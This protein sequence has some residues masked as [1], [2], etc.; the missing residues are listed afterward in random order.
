MEQT[1]DKPVIDMLQED[2]KA[3][4]ERIDIICSKLKRWR[5]QVSD[6]KT[7]ILLSEGISRLRN[8]PQD[9]M[10][11]GIMAMCAQTEIAEKK[12]SNENR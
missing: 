4:E 8:I 9:L 12:K 11:I 5:E 1:K 6:P 2:T 3:V 7:A 10:M